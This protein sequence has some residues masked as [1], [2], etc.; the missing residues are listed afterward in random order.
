MPEKDFV[1]LSKTN[2]WERKAPRPSKL[3]KYENRNREE[4]E[5]QGQNRLLKMIKINPKIKIP[6]NELIFKTSKSSGPGGQNV[7]KLNTKVTVEFDVENSQSLTNQQKNRIKHR[8]S[9]KITKNGVLQVDSQ[10]YRNQNSN[11]KDALA[12]LSSMLQ[13][14]LKKQKKRK[15]TRIPYRSK[16]KRLREKKKRSQLKKQRAM[17]DI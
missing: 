15:K 9:S 2:S 10:Q 16:Q 14:A 8:L 5:G 3:K 13:W 6:E 11:K 12:K 7:N 4:R 1:R 17:K